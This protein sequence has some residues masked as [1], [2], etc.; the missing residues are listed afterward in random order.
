MYDTGVA[1]NWP[2]DPLLFYYGGVVHKRVRPSAGRKAPNGRHDCAGRRRRD[3]RRDSPRLCDAITWWGRNRR[4]ALRKPAPFGFEYCDHNSAVSAA[5]P[6]EDQD[7]DEIPNVV[8]T[9]VWEDPGAYVQYY[10]HRGDTAR[11]RYGPQLTGRPR[12]TG[13]PAF[14]VWASFRVVGRAAVYSRP[15]TDLTL[16]GGGHD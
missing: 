10:L 14:E 5:I 8:L 4:S 1:S 13:D 3:N 9:R 11:E 15:N 16:D 6:F 12:A 7:E 2:L